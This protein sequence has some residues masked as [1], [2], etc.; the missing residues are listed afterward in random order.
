MKFLFSLALMF[1]ISAQLAGQKFENIN[2][3]FQDGKVSITYDL[4]GGQ[5]NRF[6][7]VHILS[8]HN[9]FAR[10][11]TKVTGDV[12]EGVAP[13]IGKKIIWD[14]SSELGDFAGN[15]NFK[16]NAEIIPLPFAF[17]APA[18]NKAIRRGKGTM[19]TWD[20]GRSNQT[21]KL[22]LYQGS[23]LLNTVAEV[24]NTGSYEWS[25]PRNQA[26]GLYALKLT[27]GKES[28]NS[29]EF[30]IKSKTPL[31]VKIL[32]FAVAGGVAVKLLFPGD[33]D[34]PLPEPLDPLDK[35]N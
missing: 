20:G 23:T 7:V 16:V 12:G 18:L 33:S 3:A 25:V 29:N 17:K 5:P 8:S 30:K 6:Y 10:P 27:S 9:N 32:P 1:L 15:V 14:A 13:G 2:A 21:I 34:D 19:I 28:V 35:S 11:L 22:E 26:K 31:L 4:V 24:G